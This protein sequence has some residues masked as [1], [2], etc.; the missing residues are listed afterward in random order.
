MSQNYNS[1]TNRLA[2]FASR[3]KYSQL[4]T[5]VVE[6]VKFIILDTVGCGLYG[7]RL[8]WG[9]II[10]EYVREMGG[11]DKATVWGNN[12]KTSAANAALANGTMVH[13][14]E[15]DDLHKNSGV[16][17]GG[18]TTC[19]GLAMAEEK[20]SVNGKELITAIVAGY[21]VGARIGLCVGTG[22]HS[23]KGFHTTGTVGAF[24]SATAAGKILN[25]N[26]E[27]MVHCLGMGGT[28]G[29][30]LLAAQFSS[31]VKRMHAG[32]AGQ[33]GIYAA[34]LARKGFTGITDILE[35][36]YGGFCSSETLTPPEM[37][38]LTKGLDENEFWVLDVGFKP[39][40]S[41]GST[42]TSID[43]VDAIMVENKILPEMIEKIRV[44]CPHV[45]K[46]HVG[47]EYKPDS[48]TAAQ[49]NVY[50]CIAAKV[51]EG[52]V[53]VDQFTDKK[54]K[55][56]KILNFIRDRIEVVDNPELDKL[57]RQGRHTIIMKLSTK[58]GDLYTKRVEFAKGSY[59]FPLTRAE[60]TTK[61]KTL[62]GKVL[63]QKKTDQLYETIMS[64]DALDDLRLF[65][66]LLV[67]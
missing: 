14:F 24:V 7:S 16:H 18:L 67:A 53:F 23:M 55:D 30:G 1:S 35:A 13:G 9:K 60:V 58:K 22:G 2:Q 29:A 61:F 11:N 33:S 42:H 54:I 40:S 32:R 38:Y 57:G 48:I 64:L 46:E 51:L 43:A 37:S 45:A 5:A 17:G 20:G 21:E 65:S 66:K 59:F 6:H 3:L 50:Y 34:Q 26:E 52:D 49:M 10:A 12:F 28:Q 62:A 4:P 44:E 19:A 8:P 27:E 39:Y 41:C 63:D 31:M 36:R 56:P 25:L 15:L 47:W